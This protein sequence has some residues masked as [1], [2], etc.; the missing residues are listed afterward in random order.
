MK[1]HEATGAINI[2]KYL[3]VDQHKPSTRTSGGLDQPV[4]EQLSV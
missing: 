4:T 1:L 3:C 2:Y